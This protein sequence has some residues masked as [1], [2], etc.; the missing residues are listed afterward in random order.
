M[1]SIRT[2]NWQG[3]YIF[4]TDEL[5]DIISDLNLLTFKVRML[6]ISN[7]ACHPQWPNVRYI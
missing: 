6:D 5:V 3:F 7:A 2:A 1:R 4:G